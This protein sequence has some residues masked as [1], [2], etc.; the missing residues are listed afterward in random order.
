MTRK[1]ATLP[2]LAAL[3]RTSAVTGSPKN[4]PLVVDDQRS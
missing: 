1:F 3:L 4:T 2:A